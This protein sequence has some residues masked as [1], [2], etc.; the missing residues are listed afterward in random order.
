MIGYAPDEGGCDA[1][2][3]RAPLFAGVPAVIHIP[4]HHAVR[5]HQR[6]CPRGGHAQSK[7]RFAAQKL[8]DAG[9]QHLT[10]IRLSENGRES[11]IVMYSTTLAHFHRLSYNDSQLYLN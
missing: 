7:H 2:D 10:P 9:A 11:M 1:E 5:G 6:P 3:H 4:Y 8:P